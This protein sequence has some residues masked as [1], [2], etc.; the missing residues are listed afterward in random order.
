MFTGIFVARKP[1]AGGLIK[2]FIN[3]K[4]IS[5]L[6][7]VFCISLDLDNGSS[8]YL[9]TGHF[10]GVSKK[11][12]FQ[13]H[14]WE[15]FQS[16]PFPWSCN[17]LHLSQHSFL[18]SVSSQAEYHSHGI[19]A[20][21]WQNFGEARTP[22]CFRLPPIPSPFWVVLSV[23]CVLKL[24][25]LVLVDLY[26]IHYGPMCFF[27]KFLPCEWGGGAGVWPTK[28]NSVASLDIMH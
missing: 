7:P 21:T 9:I 27:L 20:A 24:N 16:L 1:L 3:I 15:P 2:S 22:I 5:R 6:T 8:N 14:T 12:E 28:F 10:V 26:F 4:I 13:Q 25:C 11:Q 17:L 18:I 19:F 23:V